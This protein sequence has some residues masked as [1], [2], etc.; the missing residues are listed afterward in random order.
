MWVYLVLFLSCSCSLVERGSRYCGQRRRMEGQRECLNAYQCGERVQSTT[1]TIKS[2]NRTQDET[3]SVGK[4]D[5]HV[6]H[7]RLFLGL[8]VPVSFFRVSN[9]GPLGIASPG[10]A[11]RRACP[12]ALVSPFG[13][14]SYLCVCVCLRSDGPCPPLREKAKQD[15][16]AGLC[17]GVSS[18][19]SQWP[20][21]IRLGSSL[22]VILVMS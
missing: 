20:A 13:C 19:V 18:G 3:C 15:P 9:P 22:A 10:Q 8:L 7:C 16:F 11:V 17:S 21:A 2:R 14:S 6:E 12:R 4:P 1:R 5:S